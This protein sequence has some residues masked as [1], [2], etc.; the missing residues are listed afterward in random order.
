MLISFSQSSKKY[1][2]G[3]CNRSIN[4]QL[5]LSLYLFVNSSDK[6]WD[7]LIKSQSSLSLYFSIK[8][9]DKVVFPPTYFQF[10]LSL[11]FSDRKS[12]RLN[13]SHANISY[14][15]FCLKKNTYRNSPVLIPT[16]Q[17]YEMTPLC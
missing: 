16:R 9:S 13:S 11:C 7:S 1:F 10:N 12:T 14:A 8:D 4:S 2:N 5:N 6:F 15:V 17:P 3:F